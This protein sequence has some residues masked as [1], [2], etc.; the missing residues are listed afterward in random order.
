[1][2]PIPPWKWLLA[3]LV[4]LFMAVDAVKKKKLNRGGAL[5]AFMAG[6]ITMLCSYSF[7]LA[8]AAFFYS[9]SKVTKYKSHLKQKLEEDYKEGGQRT[10]V[11][12][13]TNGFVGVTFALHHALDSGFEEVP[14]D[15]EG[16]FHSTWLAI[17]VLSAFA[18]CN[19]DT[20]ASEIGSVAGPS[21]PRLITS[22]EE[23]PAGTNG[24]V[25]LVGTLSSIVGG[26]IVG[27][28]YYTGIVLTFA[29]NSRPPCQWF[30]I[31]VGAI[32]G[33]VG[34]IVDS[35]IGATLQYSG[36]CKKSKR[37]VNVPSPTVER[38]S[39]ASILSNEAVNLVASSITAVLVPPIA[40]R[41]WPS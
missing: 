34:S 17:A 1:M 8:M 12:V 18:C 7:F 35:L 27:L 15:F 14:L 37:V 3:F 40:A 2:H 36:Y 13:F 31:V 20:W 11:Q 6:F 30:V 21:R 26:A 41:I 23:V 22:W 25:T 28:G 33:F 4:P 5:M 10:W 32:A 19:G 9:G 38:I 39:G 16:N 29:Y 24:G